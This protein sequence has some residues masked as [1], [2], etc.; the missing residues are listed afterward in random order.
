M[1]QRDDAFDALARLCDEPGLNGLGRREVLETLHTKACLKEFRLSNESHIPAVTERDFVPKSRLS[2]CS[3]RS[4]E[5]PLC[6]QK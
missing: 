3:V 2:F 4:G 5:L 1:N 6:R